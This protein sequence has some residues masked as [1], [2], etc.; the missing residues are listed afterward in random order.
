MGA[1]AV[2]CGVWWNVGVQFQG[3]ELESYG[4]LM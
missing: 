2:A 1:G 3:M 4:I